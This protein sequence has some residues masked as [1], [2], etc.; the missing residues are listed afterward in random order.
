VLVVWPTFVV[1][2]KVSAVTIAPV[3]QNAD[4]LERLVPDDLK[5]GETSGYD[6]L[7]L[8]LERYE[9]AAGYA[10]AGRLLDIACGVG[11][12][13]RLLADRC[14]MVTEAVGVDLSQHAIAYAKEHYA[15]SRTGFCVADAMTFDDAAGFDTI[16]SLET[17]EHLPDPEGFVRRLVHLLRPGGFMIAS[18]PTT[19]SVDANPHHLHDFTESSFRQ[20]FQHHGFVERNSLLQVQRFALTAVLSRQ[21]QRMRQVR[22]HLLAYYLMHPASLLRRLA[23]TLRYGFV[24]RYRTIVWQAPTRGSSARH[25]DI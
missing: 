17:I 24:N 8:H 3:K 20:L 12:G 9:F 23:S 15:D 16:V 19:P 10:S 4:T 1:T 2:G 11:Y 5:V 21:E 18:A 14:G 13:T 7:Q 25:Q 22:R 6:T